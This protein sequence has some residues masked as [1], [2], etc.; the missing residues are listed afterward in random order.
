MLTLTLACAAYDRTRP[1]IDGRVAI[2]GVELRATTLHPEAAFARAKAAEFDLTELSLSGYLRS[3]D[4]GKPTY[5]ALPVFPS[6]AF[7]H[8]GI[9]VHAG[10]GIRSP[11]DLRGRTIGTPD[12]KTTANV[13]IRAFLAHDHGVQP[14][15]MQWM[16]AAME[17][18][19]PG[20]ATATAVPGVSILALPDQDLSG[21]LARGEI[22]AVV[23]AKVPSCF[24]P[25]QDDVARLFPDHQ[26]V[27]QDYYRRT[28]FFPIMHVLGLR[29]DLHERHP[30]LAQAICQG[31]EAARRMALQDLRDVCQL[32]ATLP[33]VVAEYQRTVDLMGEDYWPYGLDANREVLQ[34]FARYHFQQGLS[35]RLH[36]P[37]D[38]LA[39]ANFSSNRVTTRS[40]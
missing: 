4:A 2:E 36:S 15:E 37:G 19:E 40:A 28:G 18:G 12:Y 8:S 5:V 33:W 13:W 26:R 30:W 23:G 21:M 38:W 22:D 32:A 25:G 27:E 11:A 9:Y 20:P 16:E 14:H 34:A 3:L 1:L 6:R 29:R 7:R 39:P 17:A 10:R 35:A 24:G 31:F